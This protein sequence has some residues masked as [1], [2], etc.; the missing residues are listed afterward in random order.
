[1]RKYTGKSIAILLAMLVLGVAACGTQDEKQPQN[2][3]VSGEQTPG[4]AAN[5]G[6]D[7]QNK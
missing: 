6:E 7:A 5:Q 4:D 3:N 2:D 1:M